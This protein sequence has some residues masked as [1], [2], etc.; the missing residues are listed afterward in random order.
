MVV[1]VVDVVV[2]IVVVIVVVV[3]VGVLPLVVVV[4]VWASQRGY[5]AVTTNHPHTSCLSFRA[6]T[7]PS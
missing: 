3:A 6:G 1:V 4:V 7:S 2:A 5:E